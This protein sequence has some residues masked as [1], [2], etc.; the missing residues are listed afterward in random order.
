M[1]QFWFVCLLAGPSALDFHRL[2]GKT[3]GGLVATLKIVLL[4]ACRQPIMKGATHRGRFWSEAEP[5]FTK[6][7][8]RICYSGSPWFVSST[9][10]CRIDVHARLL[11]LRKNSPGTFIW[12]NWIL[13]KWQ[14]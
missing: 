7:M 13:I 5:S 12:V 3:V 11:I 9:L 6:D 14:C 8:A 4:L 2:P 1:G 10:V